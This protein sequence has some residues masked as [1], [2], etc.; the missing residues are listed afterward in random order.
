MRNS[1]LGESLSH[2]SSAVGLDEQRLSI[3]LEV[4]YR[5][6]EKVERQREKRLENKRKREERRE[7][8]TKREKERGI[9][10]VRSES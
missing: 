6:K 9:I 10:G 8:K 2:P 7:E 5:G 3:V 4:Y 1:P